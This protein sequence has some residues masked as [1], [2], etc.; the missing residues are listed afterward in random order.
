MQ[1]NHRKV[2]RLARNPSRVLVA[3]DAMLFDL[4]AECSSQTHCKYLARP[5]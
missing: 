4:P 5:W 1:V 3:A 2:P